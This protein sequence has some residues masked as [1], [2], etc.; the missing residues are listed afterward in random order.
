MP[1]RTCF[2]LHAFYDLFH[3]FF[4]YHQ[5]MKE[6]MDP[7]PAYLHSFPFLKVLFSV[8]C[9]RP[10]LRG[11]NLIHECQLPNNQPPKIVS[12]S[13]I[14]RIHFLVIGHFETHFSFK[15]NLQGHTLTSD[16]ISQC[17]FPG[18]L[19]FWGQSF[20]SQRNIM[21][22]LSVRMVNLLLAIFFLIASQ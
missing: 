5:S 17:I 16:V 21:W 10:N 20:L 12:T 4:P 18:S 15:T 19:I 8:L 2:M 14:Q 9:P 3:F 6:N 7:K 22:F 1:I 11:Q 13:T